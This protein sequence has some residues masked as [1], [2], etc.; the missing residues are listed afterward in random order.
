MN[1]EDMFR[2]EVDPI[3]K[4]VKDVVK[5]AEL[6]LAYFVL[7]R[8][9]YELENYDYGLIHRNIGFEIE[10]THR[11]TPRTTQEVFKLR[12][13]AIEVLM[14]NERSVTQL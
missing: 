11:I 7:S 3:N 8:N 2:T 6:D 4:T 9:D 1:V 10:R 12:A 14:R 13:M 5:R